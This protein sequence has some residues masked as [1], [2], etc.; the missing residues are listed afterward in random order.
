MSDKITVSN[1]GKIKIIVAV[2]ENQEESKKGKLSEAT[3]DIVEVERVPSTMDTDKNTY[4]KTNLFDFF[5][6]HINMR[7]GGTKKRRR[8]KK[9]KKRK[10]ASRK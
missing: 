9:G 3:F 7:G 8:R 2:N 5:H 10:T 4:T 1:L 6:Q